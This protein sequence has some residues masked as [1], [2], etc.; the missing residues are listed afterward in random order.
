[1]NFKEF[2]ESLKYRKYNNWKIAI[3]FIEFKLKNFF[4]DILVYLNVFNFNSKE[5]IDLGS[6]KDNSYINFFLYSL[7]D[8]YNFTYKNDKN[9]KKLLRRI[10]FFNF[11]KYTF[12][13]SSK[14]N[15]SK[16]KINMNSKLE[17]NEIS[18]DTNYF[19]F[20][21]N[22]NNLKDTNNIIMPYFM[23]PRIYNSFYKKINT[24]KEPNLNLRIFFSGSIVEEGY[25]NFYWKKEPEK[26][27]NRIKIIKSILKEFKSEIYLINSKKDLKSSDF[28]KKKIILCL[29]DKV[30]KKTSYK[31]NFNDNLNLLSQSCFNLNCPGVVMPLCHHLIEGI[32][33]GSIPITNCE[34]FLIPN[35]NNENSLIYSNLDQLKDKIHEA[36]VMKDDQIILMRSNLQKYYKSNLS[37]ESFKENFKKVLSEEKNKIICCDD[38]RSIE[39][40][41]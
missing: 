5:I 39:G 35:L 26:F 28:S 15:D 11:F 17:D 20:F 16:I 10:G 40:M 6:F 30:M 2:K 23:Y 12:S 41:I 9:A 3:R 25:S 32:K 36:L 14:N 29:H 38:H 31:L 24:S 34:K 4:L 33:V 27:P 21:Y 1:M 7:K 18:I 8:Q 37:P 13:N 22:K 19:Q